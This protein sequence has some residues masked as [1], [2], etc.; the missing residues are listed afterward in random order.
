[1]EPILIGTTDR[2]I[3][4]FIPDPASTD[5]SGKTGLNAAALEAS[6]TRVET[7]NDVIVTDVTSSLNDLSALTDAHNDWGLK[8]VSST[9]A[10]GLY[11]LDVA[12]ALFASGAWYAVLY[13]KIS[14]SEASA[15]PKLF[16]LVA[17][18]ELDGV[19]LGLT[20]LPNA[21]AAAAGGLIILGSNNTAAITIGALTTGAIACTTI[22][23]SG[24]VAFQ[25]TFAVTTSTALGALSCS[26]LT[27][28][29]AVAFQ[30]TF[31]V[32]TS[33]S[34][35][36]LSCTTLTAS[37]TTSLAAVTTSGTVTMNALTVTNATTLSGAVSL[38][39]TLGITGAI[40][41]T[42]ASNNLRLGTF[43]VDINAIA[44]PAAWDAEVQSEVQDAIEA[45]HLDHLLAATYDPA[46]KPGAADALLNELV[47]SDA[48]VSRY[49]ANAL[50]QAPTGGSAPTVA[51][52]RTEMDDNSTKLAAIVADT[53]ELQTDWANG[54]RLDLILDIIAADTTTDIPAL[55]AALNNLSAAQVNAEVLDVL[56]T[57]TFAE[58]S[59]PPAATASL[60]DKL[61]WMAALHR[62]KRTQTATTEL[63][64]NDADNATIGTATKSDDGTTYIRGEYS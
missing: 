22:T 43:T 28:S 64:R 48:G 29:G 27:A 40:T 16:R 7:D 49:T 10:E 23:A 25:S 37:G 19:R 58:P 30:S 60:K 63:V 4:I 5:G 34:L 41:A 12:D 15:T 62:N 42:N 52:I 32:T 8:E 46:S 3:L 1:M 31:A 55:I 44:W 57:D 33:T 18:N 36:A 39:S 21:A 20:A 2:S 11:R 35:A 38:G 51:Q 45:N 26:T 56:V 6:Y 61:G 47:E 13:V 50:E 14:A 54:G 24:A 9:L 17:Y 53:N 59:A